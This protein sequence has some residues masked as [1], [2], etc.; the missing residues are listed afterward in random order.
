MDGLKKLISVIMAF[1]MVTGAF[2]I[3]L[4]YSTASD[5]S[6]GIVD[7]TAIDLG[8][9]IRAETTTAEDILSSAEAE[10]VSF[11]EILGSKD[12]AVNDIAYYY[13]W[14]YGATNWM[15]FAKLADGDHCEVWVALDCSFPQ[16]A[17]NNGTIVVDQAD[18]EYMVQQFD[19]VIYPNETAYFSDAPALN[20]TNAALPDLIGNSTRYFNTTDAG[21]TMIMVFN[22]VDTNYNDPDYPYYV[23]GFYTPNT[24][25]YYDRNIINIDCFDW[26]NRTTGTSNRPYVYEGTVAH[27]YQHLLH[28]YVDSAETTW[29]NEGCSMY[30]EALCGYG[31][32]Y[33][34][35]AQF[36]YT[37]D[38]SLTDWG[39][40][41]D[42]NILADYGAA[43]LFMI[44]MNDHYGGSEVISAIMQNQMQGTD[45]I[46]DCLRDLGY[47]TMT[48]D[49]VFR[50]W[51]LA[52]LLWTDEV[53][54][55][56]YNYQSI[57][58]DD[59][60]YHGKYYNGY[61][62][63]S[64]MEYDPSDGLVSASSYFGNAYNIDQMYLYE[65]RLGAY[66]TDY[67]Q[68]GRDRGSDPWEDYIQALFSKFVFDGD[69]ELDVGW[70][71]WDDRRISDCWYT[72][73]DPAVYYNSADYTYNMADFLL[74]TELNLTGSVDQEYNNCSHW[75]NMTTQW[76]IEDDTDY[77]GYGYDFGFVQISIDGGLTWT[78]LNDT[79]DYCTDNY[80]TSVEGIIENLPGITGSSEGTV[81][82][83]FNLTAYDGQKVMLG[84]RY[85]TDQMT[86]L[87][88][89]FIEEVSVDDAIIPDSA[90][91]PVREETNFL[92]TIVGTGDDISPMIMNIP[93][94]LATD[95]G[96]RLLGPFMFCDEITILVS[97]TVGPADYSFGIEE[98]G[99]FF[100]E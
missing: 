40:Q 1:T 49:K 32:E 69:S 38:N 36:L 79:G 41:S 24:P 80:S 74:I 99:G 55:G 100:R 47:N 12:F 22:I 70:T 33:S 78:S 63:I 46:T 73:I 85:M 88:G 34:D 65:S 67:I 25:Y 75:L 17:R 18:A 60:Y 48:F 10:G 72:G 84:F 92:V 58:I 66:G 93:T 37:P 13:T 31:Y 21:K 16:S 50:N 6:S 23:V 83:N 30:A 52:N 89:W 8:Y 82:L 20:G 35:I 44:Y 54:G 15:E 51:R 71:Y 90:F 14:G 4:P 95:D 27:E 68:V 26:D 53:G 59:I 43:L 28:D 29:I 91:T 42:D 94:N 11:D 45:S 7:P 77:P 9:K 2:A 86:T 76:N 64:P 97:P 61:V 87:N 81:D 98:R 3:F 5:T 96:Q 62:T 39:D 56:I 57:S 19:D